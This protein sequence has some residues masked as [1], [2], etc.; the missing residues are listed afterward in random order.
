MQ[1]KNIL[2]V[3]DDPE[4]SDFFKTVVNQINQGIKVIT[5]SSKKELFL[6]L[7]QNTPDLLFIDSFIQFD[8]GLAS[9]PEIRGANNFQHLPIIM[10]TGSADLKNINAA[11]AVGASAYIVKPHSL[12]EIKSVVQ[13]VLEQDWTKPIQRQYYVDGKFYD[14]ND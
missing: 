5:A 14:F 7:E 2:I 8:S 12:A 9:I 4:D 1:I 11:F 3:D 10:Y 6:S 13:K